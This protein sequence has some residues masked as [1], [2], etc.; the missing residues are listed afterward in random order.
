MNLH[1]SKWVLGSWPPRAAV[2]VVPAALAVVRDMVKSLAVA[3]GM[4]PEQ[5]GAHSLRIAGATALFAA[6]FGE[7][8]R[9]LAAEAELTV[10]PRLAGWKPPLTRAVLVD[11]VV[12]GNGEIEN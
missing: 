2:R 7:K 8:E 11:R 12:V 5:F 9:A 10:E 4:D 1:R 3:L 6:A